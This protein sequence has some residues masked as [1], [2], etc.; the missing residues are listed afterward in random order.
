MTRTP[1]ERRPNATR[2]GR[3]LSVVFA[4]ACA[5]F[6]AHAAEAQGLREGKTAL[7]EGR[8]D[9]A[10]A[11]YRS[12]VQANPGD[13]QANRGLGQALEKKRLWAASLE[14]F[15]KA[16]QLDPRLAEPYRGQGANLLRLNK[17]AEAEVAFRKAIEIDR[18]CA[19]AQLGLGEALVRQNKV[20][21]AIAVLEQGVKFGTKTAPMF[22]QGLGKAEA[23][24]DS[25]QAAEVWLLKAREAAPTSAAIQRS[26]G[27]LYMQR[28]I[29][30]LAIVS[31]EEA[32]SLDASDLDARM[33]LGDAYYGAARYNDALNEYKAV[34]EANPDY[35]EGYQKLGHLYVLASR[36]DPQRTFDAIEALEKGR[37]LDPKNRDIL[38]DLA[39]AYYRKGGAEGKAKAKEMI[40]LL[41]AEG[42][43]PPDA[44]RVGAILLYENKDYAAAA[45]A[46]AAVKSLEP[47]DRFRQADIYRRMAVDV[48]DSTQ[49]EV[50]YASA[51]SVL[52]ILVNQD[53]TTADGKKAQFE[54]ARL[55]YLRKDYPRAIPQ[56]ERTIML[57]SNSGESYYYLGLSQRAIGDDAAGAASLQKAVELDPKQAS[58]W[59]QV[60]AVK[61]KLDQIPEALQ[62]FQQAA[63][64]DSSTS[65]AI[66][67]Q[68]I[69]YRKLLE[70]KYD[71]AIR[72]LEESA[73]RD[74]KQYITWVWLGQARQNSGDRGGAIEAYRKALELKPG[75]PNAT[76][77]LKSLGQ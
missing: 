21:E 31:Y 54:R 20:P 45:N 10:V 27:D 46:Y 16:G 9:D 74:P 51:D 3:L 49:K 64:L 18:K 23:A 29:P 61:L 1:N 73:R 35:A 26:L 13:A 2:H 34:V 68:Q 63:D 14:S 30:S 43:L 57:D 5:L 70:K 25:L 42:P 62:A 60:G 55:L 24:R 44:A 48:P 19:D 6:L 40:D 8:Y 36:A 67:L 52:A 59:I 66:G 76:K 65:G 58:W 4:L 22:Y 12:A 41:A 39:Q 75:E 11:A 37:A 71:E 32:K 56:L 77:G 15:Q 72:N 7:E 33:S 38:A 28:K 17:P 50:Y 53:S 69:G 47:T